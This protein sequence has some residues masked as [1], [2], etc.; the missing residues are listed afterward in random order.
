[1][2]L[3]NLS[4][5]QIDE[6][7]N[8]DDAL[9]EKAKCEKSFYEFVKA[10]WH[11]VEPGS[12]FV[13]GKH[14]HAI[15]EHLEAIHKGYIHNLLINVPPRHTKS[16]LVAVLF[17][18]WVWTTRPGKQ[19]M[20]ASSSA[21]VS[22]RDAVKSRRIINSKWYQ[23]HWGNKF[24]MRD[25]Q[26]KKEKY[27]NDQF[28]HRISTSV[29][30]T[31]IGEGMDIG[32]I[33]D[34]N[35]PESATS[36]T[37]SRNVWE[38]Y[39]EAFSTRLNNQE[40]GRK[41]CIMQ[42]LSER[43]LSQF[44]L[45]GDEGFVHLCLPYEFDEQ[46]RCRTSIGWVDWREKDGDILWPERNTQV[47]LDKAKRSLGPYGV[48]G[49]LQQR[50]APRGGGLFKEEYFA[51]LPIADTDMV[52]QV[53]AWDRAVSLDGDYTAGAKVGQDKNGNLWL[54]D[55]CRFR[56][57]VHEVRQKIRQT[58][59]ADG[60]K[61]HVLLEQE[62]GASGKVE[63]ESMIR[64]LMGFVVVAKSHQT[65]KVTRALPVVSQVEAGNIKMVR[66]SWNSKFIEEVIV[67]PHGKN[68]D[69]VDAFCM[70]CNHLMSHKPVFIA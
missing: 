11:T 44:L 41:I 20:C 52:K 58:A 46:A 43:D 54:L 32:I 9:I 68:D 8:L 5:D 53:R 56:G 1:M 6:I 31:I 70:A 27:E 39:S 29:L 50:P 57:R 49:Q 28:G 67:F 30:K 66:G 24:S 10:A 12:P 3:G 35:S 33:D 65:N 45:D 18:C 21:G 64:D 34:P 59:E 62:P 7:L 13:D 26:N 17:P 36:E 51:P 63:V 55:M 15:C 42:R 40:D 38:W 19:F 2:D 69:Q 25:D 60:E 16:L 4:K 22:I 47:S 61:C 48:A 14:I 37:Q 23:K